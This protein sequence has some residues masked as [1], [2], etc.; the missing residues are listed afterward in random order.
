MTK[1]VNKGEGIDHYYPGGHP[2]SLR[3]DAGQVV[4]V[5]DL[6][7][8]E[9]DDCYLVGEG[10]DVRAWPKTRW[11]QQGTPASRRSPREKDTKTEEKW[12]A[13]VEKTLEMEGGRL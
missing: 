6:K 9:L 13:R 11:E 5:G 10:D 8:E 4:D 3:V 7:V 12:E 2:D 1:F